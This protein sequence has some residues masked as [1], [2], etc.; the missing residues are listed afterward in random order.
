M[1]MFDLDA[2]LAEIVAPTPATIAA[3]A[4]NGPNVAKVA[5]VAARPVEKKTH[6]QPAEIAALPPAALAAPAAKPPFAAIAAAS[7]AKNKT[8]PQPAEVTPQPPRPAPSRPQPEGFSYGRSFDGKP[9]TWTGKVVSLDEWRRLS[10][11]DKHGST[12]KLFCGVCS[13]W[14]ASD[15]F[16]NCH[17][18]DGGAA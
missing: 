13:A 11:W 17:G 8:K 16:P 4:A 12:G 1:R 18:T 6:P 3:P 14:V 10:E 7:H 2:A 5:D 15:G 9:L